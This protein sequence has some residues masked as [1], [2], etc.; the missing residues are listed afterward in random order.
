VELASPG[1]HQTIEI[2]RFSDGHKRVFS[3]SVP[4]GTFAQ[5]SAWGAVLSEHLPLVL[6]LIAENAPLRTICE[7]E[8]AFTVGEAYELTKILRDDGSHTA[9]R[10]VNTGTIEP[11][12]TLWGHSPT[13]YLK[14]KYLR[15]TISRVAFKQKFP[16]R[17]VQMTSPKIIISG[18]RHFEAILDLSGDVIAGK[19]T[20]VV[21]GI[22][23]NDEWMCLLGILNS[24]LAKFFLK[25]CYSALAMDGGINFSPTNV[26]EIPIAAPF[27][28]K[29]LLRVVRQILAIRGKSGPNTSARDEQSLAALTNALDQE[30]FRLYR[31]TEREKAIV[32]A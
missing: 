25:E 27:V 31:L 6:R 4:R 10:F 28:S 12:F 8:E 15:P 1:E 19:S 5:M 16:K 11:F 32:R 13:T 23:H 22:A 20:V 29:E 9:F 3:T 14:K 24:Q 18:M 21:R 7:L 26:G 30:V 17:Y 2:A